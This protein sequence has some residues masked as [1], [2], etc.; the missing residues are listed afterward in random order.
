MPPSMSTKLPRACTMVKVSKKMAE[1]MVPDNDNDNN[2][3]NNGNTTTITIIIVI[4]I[5]P[6]LRQARMI[7]ETIRRRRIMLV[8]NS[9]VSRDMRV[10]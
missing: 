2:N 7:I 4:V 9:R 5:V 10:Q 3:D 8:T 6:C 1:R